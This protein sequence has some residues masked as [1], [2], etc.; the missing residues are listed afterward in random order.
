PRCHGT[1]LRTR[2]GSR[3]PRLPGRPDAGTR[4]GHALHPPV[5][6]GLSLMSRSLPRFYPIFDSA[7][8]LARM[9]PLGVRFVQ[10][11]IK[12]GSEAEVRREIRHG[13]ALARQYGATVVVNDYWQLAIE[14]G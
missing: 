4:H 12:E 10:L 14:E 2:R 3:T 13:L 1:R 9:L 5:W 11:R 6:Q 8:W 7:D